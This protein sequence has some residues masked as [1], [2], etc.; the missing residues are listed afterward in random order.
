MRRARVHAIGKDIL[1][2]HAVYWP[3]ILLAAG[4]PLPTH[5][6]VHGFLTINGAKMSKTTG[7]VIDPVAVAE[8]YRF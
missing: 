5:V 7:N 2:F 6:V 4:V 8:Q 1:R 3:G